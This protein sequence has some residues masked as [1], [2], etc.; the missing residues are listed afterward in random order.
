V[1]RR[2]GWRFDP[3]NDWR[4][5]FWPTPIVVP[6]ALLAVLVRLPEY[7]G[8]ASEALAP[9]LLVLRYAEYQE[10]FYAVFLLLYLGSFYNR[11]KHLA[12]R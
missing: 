11:L 3:A 1:A 12:A 5:W 7:V 2:K 10:Y 9:Y 8:E 4:P 6:T